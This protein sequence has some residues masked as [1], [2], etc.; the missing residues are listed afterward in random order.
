MIRSAK[1]FTLIELL[2][3]VNIVAIL[4]GTGSILY[5]EYGSEA[6]CSE[7]Y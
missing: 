7:I 3:V 6:K 5:S 2:V 1:G 4:A